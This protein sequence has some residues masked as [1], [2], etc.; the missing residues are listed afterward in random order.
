MLE[1]YRSEHCMVTA[2]IHSPSYVVVM[3]K[4]HKQLSSTINRNLKQ[5]IE[6]FNG[7][8]YVHN[9]SEADLGSIDIPVPKKK[10]IEGAGTVRLNENPE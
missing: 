6:S 5:I 9:V 1:R 4:I 2:V 3:Y 8:M 10:D 7:E